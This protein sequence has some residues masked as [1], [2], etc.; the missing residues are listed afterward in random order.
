ML[1]GGHVDGRGGSRRSLRPESRSESRNYPIFLVEMIPDEIVACTRDSDQ[2][3]S[4]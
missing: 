4:R 2:E 1:V 3:C